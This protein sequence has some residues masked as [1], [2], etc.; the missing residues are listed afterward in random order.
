L[1]AIC[2]LVR[3]LNGDLIPFPGEGCV[4]QEGDELL[5]WGEVGVSA[6]IAWLLGRTDVFEMVL[7]DVTQ[8]STDGH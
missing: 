7:A 8:P 4:L 5:I 3:R 6:R 2:L 1:P